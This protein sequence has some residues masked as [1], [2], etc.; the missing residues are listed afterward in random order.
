MAKRKNGEGSWGTKTIKGKQ[1][2]YYRNSEG[3]YFYGKTEKEVKEKIKKYTPLKSINKDIKKMYFGDYILDW[4]LKV[5]ANEIKRH[6]LDGYEDCINGQL[7][8]NSKAKISNIQVGAL[9]T[10]DFIEYYNILTT[11][12]SRATIKK[13]YAILSQCVSYGNKKQHFSSIIDFSEIKLPHEDNVKNKKKEIQFLTQA[14]MAKLYQESKRI[15]TPGFNFGGKIGEPTYGNNANLLMFIM[16]TGLRISEAIDLQWEDINLEAKIPVVNVR[17][18]SVKLKDRTGKSG[19]KYVQSSS[20]TK[21]SSGARTIPLNKQ[22]LEI[23]STEQELNPKHKDTDYVF[24]TKNGEKIKSRQNVTR[25]LAK[26]MTRADCSISTCTPHELR[27][28]FGSALIKNG[29]DIKVVSQLLGHSDISVTYNVYIHIL[30]DQKVD[31]IKSLDSIL[32]Q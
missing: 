16:F 31:A 7:I 32:S 17:S 1:Y 9:T 19:K 6:T 25:T 28:S 27:H 21:T 11:Q 29:T 23:I 20:S 14:D 30:E 13:N 24:I 8:N 22:A 15:N 5:K 3:K 10:D 4:L 18:T 26:M 2:K 12:Y